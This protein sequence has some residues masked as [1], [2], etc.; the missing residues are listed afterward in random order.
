VGWKFVENFI[1]RKYLSTYGFVEKFQFH[2]NYNFLGKTSEKFSPTRNFREK[3]I[4]FI[5]YQ[6]EENKLKIIPKS[7]RNLNR[8]FVIQING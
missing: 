8:N 2:L 1:G 5:P 7:I 3:I 4:S 6:F